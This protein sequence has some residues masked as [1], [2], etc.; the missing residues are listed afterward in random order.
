[1]EP[2]AGQAVHALTSRWARSLPAGNSVMSAL[3]LW[4]LLAIM[5][6][7]ADEPGR[8]ELAAAVGLPPE[9]S[10]A[11]G[12]GL[13]RD[14]DTS[15]DLHAALGVW[16]HESLKLSESF[17]EVVPAELVGALT[18]DPVRDK[19]KLDAWATAHTDGMIEQMPIEVTPDLAVVLA[20]ALALRTTWVRPFNEQIKQVY[21][22]PWAGG[23]W[24]WLNRTDADLTTIKRYDDTAAGPLTVATVTGDA[25][26]DILLAIGEPRAGQHDVLAGL[27]QAAA[28][29]AG[30]RSGADLIGGGVGEQVSPAVQ[31]A[32]STTPRPVVQLSLPSFSISMEHDLLDQAE[33]FGLTTVSSDPGAQGHFTAI[34]PTPLRLGQAKQTVLARFFAK[35]FE[36]AAVTAMGMVRTSMPMERERKLVVDLDRPFAF[37]AVH[38]ATRLPIVTGWL[39]T[40]SEPGA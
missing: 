28:D 27:L 33:L 5:A 6:T 18:G 13:I 10:A 7:A 31:V 38:R 19:A 36:A 22:G 2:E 16:V 30:G 23:S 26:V 8:A 11:R 20:T 29:P 35:G 24:H 32:M 40:P 25:D 17:G 21:D 39:A 4:P 1:M 15:H 12:A 37:T 9:T 34:S 14:I 3:G